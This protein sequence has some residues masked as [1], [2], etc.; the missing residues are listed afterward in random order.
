MLTQGSSA[1]AG[2][3]GMQREAS[4]KAA[5]ADAHI[6]AFVISFFIS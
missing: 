6:T 3:G 1:C 2:A 4:A 5:A